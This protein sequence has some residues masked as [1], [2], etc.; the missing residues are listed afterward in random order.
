M[1][2]LW[3]KQGNIKV[4]PIYFHVG[5]VSGIKTCKTLVST[6]QT[7][8]GPVDSKRTPKDALYSCVNLEKKILK[9]VYQ[10]FLASNP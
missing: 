4:S 8:W 9:N 3:R 2:I 5:R 6:Y 10:I 1:K 7:H